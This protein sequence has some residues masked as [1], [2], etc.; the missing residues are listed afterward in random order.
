MKQLREISFEMARDMGLIKT[1]TRS[2]LQDY[3]FF[4]RGTS[5]TDVETEKLYREMD[6]NARLQKS[7]I[8]DGEELKVV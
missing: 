6:N 7:V 2:E 3:I 8:L 1:S 5:A 4:K